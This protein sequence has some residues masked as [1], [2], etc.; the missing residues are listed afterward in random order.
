MYPELLAEANTAGIHRHAQ[1]QGPSLFHTPGH[2]THQRSRSVGQLLPPWPEN[3]HGNNG[4]A[5][6]YSGVEDVRLEDGGQ[7]SDLQW[8]SGLSLKEAPG[9]RI[10]GNPVGQSHTTEQSAASSARLKD[11]RSG[12]AG[13]GEEPAR[14]LV[15]EDLIR[16]SLGLWVIE[17]RHIGDEKR[18]GS[19]PNR[20]QSKPKGSSNRRSGPTEFSGS[21]M[22]CE[23]APGT[24]MSVVDSGGF[25]CDDD[26]SWQ[27]KKDIAILQQ[28]HQQRT[29]PLQMRAFYQVQ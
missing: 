19:A 9:G 28:P 6:S 21:P 4:N 18:H 26:K 11:R 22:S 13:P 23:G 27:Q 25:F 5:R 7:P 17:S 3:S 24:L 20:M 10:R 16:T 1:R 12:A 14:R 2:R 15:P 29:S 8:S